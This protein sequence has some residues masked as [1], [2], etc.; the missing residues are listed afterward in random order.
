MRNPGV[1]VPGTN[2]FATTPNMPGTNLSLYRFSTG[3]G[4]VKCSGCHGSTHAEFPT[5][6]ASDNVASQQHQGH[7][8]MLMECDRLPCGASRAPSTSGPH[9]MH[10]IGTSSPGS[11]AD[12]HN[13]IL[14][15]TPM[16][17]PN[18]APATAPTTKAPPLSR[19]QADRS[20]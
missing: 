19:A 7:A 20:A 4:G 18:A 14:E 5:S 16:T 12:S 6:F 11:W 8:G 1:N 15:Q 9:G 10:P 17:G 2:Q 3:H 13:D